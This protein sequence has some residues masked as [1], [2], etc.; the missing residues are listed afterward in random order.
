[1]RNIPF[2][3]VIPAA[4]T[5]NEYIHAIHSPSP[6][7]FLL[8][9]SVV[10]LPEHIGMSKNNGKK[11]FVHADMIDGLDGSNAAVDF[12]AALGASGVISTRAGVV[13]YAKSIGLCTVRRF[14]IV[15]GQSLETALDNT[16]RLF[17]DYVELMPGLT[18]KV[19]ERFEPLGVPVIA[20]GLVENK[21]ERDDAFAC[22]AYAVSSSHWEKLAETTL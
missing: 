15:D 13:K 4:R 21:R 1:M 22:G 5:E 2:H 8:C 10:K 12:L 16:A 7:V 14:F 20:G 3:A 9:D 19:F 17:P 6:C 11:L 18:G